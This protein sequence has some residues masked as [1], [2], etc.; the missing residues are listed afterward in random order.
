LEELQNRELMGAALWL[1][2]DAATVAEGKCRN[3]VEEGCFVE[4]ADNAEEPP[5]EIRTKVQ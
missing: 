5:W 4:I 3:T 1:R 2:R